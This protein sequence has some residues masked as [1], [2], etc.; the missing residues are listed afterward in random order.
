M[1]DDELSGS[2]SATANPVD[3]LVLAKL[4]Q[5]GTA[6][7]NAPLLQPDP[8]QPGVRMISGVPLRVSAGVTPGTIWGVPGD[9]A[10]IIVRTD[11]TVT[12]DSSVFF[13]SDRVAVRGTMRCGFSF[14]HPAAIV[15]MSLT[16]GD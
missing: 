8:A 7:A 11:A 4:K 5:Y 1:L 16:E 15:K 6:Q 14:P 12:A 9:R 10:H 13:T 3:A 2:G